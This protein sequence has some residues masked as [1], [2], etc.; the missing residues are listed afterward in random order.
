M[1][2]IRNPVASNRKSEVLRQMDALI[3]ELEVCRRTVSA[4]G[5][6]ALVDFDTALQRAGNLRTLIVSERRTD[7]E[8][9]LRLI[10]LLCKVVEKLYAMINCNFSRERYCESW[11]YHKDA[12][13]VGGNFASFSCKVPRREPLVP[14]A[15]RER[16]SRTRPTLSE[17]DCK[18]PGYSLGVAP[19]RRGPTWLS[20]LQ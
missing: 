16:S 20:H 11:V 10:L 1:V 15:G 4:E 3:N 2:G 8:A 5:F 9:V 7:W 6:P 12:E 14:V 17:D 18:G 13:N 19:D